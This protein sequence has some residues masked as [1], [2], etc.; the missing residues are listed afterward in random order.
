MGANFL[1]GDFHLPAADE[2]GEDVARANVEIGGEEGL[3]L[4]FA[5]GIAHEEPT[6]RD[7]WHAA[8]IPDGGAAG[9]LDDAVG[10]TVPEADA[11]ALPGDVGIV[12]DGGEFSQ[13]LALDRRPAPAFALLRREIEQVGIEVQASDDADML[14]IRWP[15]T[16]CRR[17]E[18]CSDQGASGG[19][20]GRPAEPNR[21]ASWAHAMCR[22]RS[23][24]TGRAA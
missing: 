23:A 16:R 2:P 22:H 8:T 21:A 24:W 9:D 1:E 3:W 15:R 7:R 13:P 17:P 20:A 18:R 14:G 19:F 4:E 10:S 12:E 5:G 11:E 6:D